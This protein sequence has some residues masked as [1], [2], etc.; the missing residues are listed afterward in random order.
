MPRTGWLIIFSLINRKW[1]MSQANKKTAANNP[2][3]FSRERGTTLLSVW[4]FGIEKDI[5]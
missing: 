5:L 2:S 4:K 1:M 3:E